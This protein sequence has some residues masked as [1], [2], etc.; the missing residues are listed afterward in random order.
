VS[1]Q[2]AS[3]AAWRAPEDHELEMRLLRF[4]EAHPEVLFGGGAGYRQALI[5][6][7]NGETVITRYRLEEL[8]DKLDT[9]ISP[10][11]AGE[12][13]GDGLAPGRKHPGARRRKDQPG[14]PG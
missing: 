10:P 6:E 13:P 9:L 1:G 12:T 7:E 8:L 11:G 4:Q 14:P 5:P 2:A 3:P